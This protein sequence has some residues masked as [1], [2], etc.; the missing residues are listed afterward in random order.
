MILGDRLFRPRLCK[1]VTFFSFATV[2]FNC[3]DF[4][5]SLVTLFLI[6]VTLVSDPRDPLFDPRD[7]LFDPRDPRDPL[8]DPRDPRF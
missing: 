1:L 3:R 8:F 4:R 6:F 7:P 5:A 2:Y